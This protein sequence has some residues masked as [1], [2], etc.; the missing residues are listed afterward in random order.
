MHIHGNATHLNSASLHS[1]A[2]AARSA[3]AQRA[4]DT[5]KKLSAGAA[6]IAADSGPD[7]TVMIGHWLGDTQ[8]QAQA[9]YQNGITQSGK[10]PSFG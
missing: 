8:D 1:A 3:A 6:G 10:D 9:P 5:R 7:A 2:G 4:A